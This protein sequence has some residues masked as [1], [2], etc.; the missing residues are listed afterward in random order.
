VSQDFRVARESVAG[1]GHAGLRRCRG[2][3]GAVLVELALTI[4][5][6]VMVLLGIFTGGLA[7]NQKL[8]VTNG[9]REGSRFG[10]TL[11]V[12]NSVCGSGSGSLD[13]WLSQIADVTQTSSET[14]LDSSV[15]SRR[16]CV[17]YVHPDGNTSTDQT[18]SLTRTSAGDSY[19]GSSCFSD[20]RPSNER[21]VQVTGSRTA[22]IELLLFTM[23]PTMSSQSV[24]R[25]EGA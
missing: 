14:N 19:S 6:L 1:G 25:F 10:A 2:D 5:L 23:T 16:I 22:T 21:R 13:C 17:A 12:A 8:A 20:G 3:R 7:W 11:P 24:S 18:R 4:S 9:V 15:S